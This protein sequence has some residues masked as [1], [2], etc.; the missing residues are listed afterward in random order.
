MLID[1]HCHLDVK[2]LDDEFDEVLA[3]AEAAGVGGMVTIC[4]RVDEFPRVLALAERRDNIWCSVGLHPHDAAREPELETSDLVRRS[5]HPKVVGIGECGLDFHYDKS[6]RDVQTVQFLKHIEAARETGLP[7][8]VHSR[9]ADAEMAEI[10]RAEM[11]KGA[12]PGVMHC[13]SSGPALAEAA[14]DVG[15]YLSFSGILT[16][17][18]ADQLRAIAKATPRERILVETDSPFLAPVP[19]RG[20]RC[21]PAFV[22]HTANALAALLGLDAGD[23][24]RLTTENFHRLFAKAAPLARD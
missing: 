13:F 19:M 15:F 18:T 9:A 2:G 22:A 24:A 12:F 17:K 3:R 14:L 10:L 5:A 6:P 4:T 23:V 8:I 7:L 1:S 20:K 11:K 16:F 21:E